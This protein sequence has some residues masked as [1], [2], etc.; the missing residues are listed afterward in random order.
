MKKLIMA[1]VMFVAMT[2]IAMA[3][4]MDDDPL[5]GKL[6]INELEVQSTDGPD[7]LAFSAD[8]WLGFDLNKF[9]FKTEVERVD[10]ETEEAE[11]QFLYSR[12]IAPYWDIQAGWRRDIRPKPERDWFS[13]GFKGVAPYFFE[14]DAELFFGES[15]QVNVRLD[16]EYEVFFT[17]KI[18]LTPEI[19]TSFYSKDDAA[20]GIGSGFSDLELGLRLRYEIRREF[21]PYIGINWTKKF[22]QTADFASA[23]GIDTSDVQIVAGVRA[24]Y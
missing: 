8:A 21:A 1:T 22:G 19:E 7:P 23:G 4:G 5:V 15:G 11:V 10:G 6:M 18:I 3:S 13:V 2:T 16:G 9:W 12:A 24:W 14:V 20:V 17:Q